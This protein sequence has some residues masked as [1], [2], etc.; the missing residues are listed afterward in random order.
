MTLVSHLDNHPFVHAQSLDEYCECAA[1]LYTEPRL[2]IAPKTV[3]F[4][5]TVNSFKFAHSSL[6]FAG[7]NATMQLEFPAVD[8]YLQLIPIRGTGEIS[9]GNHTAIV[10]PDDCAIISPDHGYKAN[11]SA[12][13]EMLTLA[14]D[15]QALTAK[16]TALTGVHV[17]KPLHIELQQ[18][19]SAAVA[20]SLREYV[21]LLV[22]TISTADAQLPHWRIK[23]GE[24]LVMSMLLCGYEH[25][26]SYLLER[27]PLLAAERQVREVEEY[28]DANWQQPITL[29][30]LAEVSGV[31]AFDLCNTF[32][33]IRGYSP[34]EFS[35]RVRS[36]GSGKRQ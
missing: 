1:K 18:V 10:T 22:D 9:S 21:E 13:R 33:K 20:R 6:S 30:T 31:S 35:A 27:D 19:R 4:N 34:L 25:N 28:I 23:Q 24:E 15:A 7:Y 36:T 5:A 12:N 16:L 32:Q 26:Y 17:N 29:E 14:I 8:Q 2:A 11:Y 3:A